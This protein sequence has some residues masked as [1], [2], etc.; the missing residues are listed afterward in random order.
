MGGDNAPDMVVRGAALSVAKHPDIKIL[1]F[2]DKEKLSSLI[3]KESALKGRVELIHTSEIITADMKPSTALRGSKNSSMRLAIEAVK[4][5]RADAVVSAGNTGAYMALSKILL[6]MLEGIDRP[7]ITSVL[8]SLVGDVVMLDLGA[9]VECS[10]ENL[11]QFAIMGEVFARFV[12]NK[13]NPSVGLLNV[14]AEDLKGNS[15]IREAHEFLKTN[16]VVPNLYGFV[17]GDD[18]AKGTVDV[19][20]TDGFTG[21]VAL[22]SIEGTVRL[23]IGHLRKSLKKSWVTR[24]VSPLFLPILQLL[25]QRLDPRRHNGAIFLGL[26]GI[27]VKSHGGTDAFGFSHA[28]GVAVDIVNNQV[29][30]RICAELKSSDRLAAA[31]RSSASG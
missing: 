3:K 8:P 31:K 27:A 12:L 9:N 30:D 22:K 17:E 29:N 14:G 2:G 25:R 20:V 19:V 11:V 15:T 6:R 28:V 24:L 7:A 13:K 10:A 23:V 18:F 4:E 5:G 1:L 26:N 21:N 16:K